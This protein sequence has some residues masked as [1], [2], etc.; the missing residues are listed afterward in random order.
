[1]FWDPYRHS[2]R[3]T[4]KDVPLGYGYVI[5]NRNEFRSVG[6]DGCRSQAYLFKEFGL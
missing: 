2:F 4:T 1:M 6:A 5:L 3:V